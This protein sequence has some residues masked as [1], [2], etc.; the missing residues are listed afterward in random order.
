MARSC[1]GRVRRHVRMAKADTAIQGASVGRPTEPCWSRAA[2][3]AGD[4]GSGGA[5]VVRTGWAAISL[6]TRLR[7]LP[8]ISV[9]ALSCAMVR[10]PA[11]RNV[12]VPLLSE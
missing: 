5:A 4:A 2:G 3:V 11:S 12:V 7:L 9:L 10:P 6:T 8:N 1:P